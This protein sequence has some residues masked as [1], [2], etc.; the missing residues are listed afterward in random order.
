MSHDIR[1]GCCSFVFG[2]ADLATALDLAR[3]LGF[4]HV[5]V[6]AAD[7]GPRANVDQEQ[8]VADP[9]G[10]AERVRALADARS[11]ELDEVFLCPVF[12]KGKRVEV[13]TGD[14]GLREAVVE[15]FGRIC[16]FAAAA[17][18]R[19]IMAVPGMPREGVSDEAAREHAVRTLRRLVALGGEAGLDI[20]IEPH[21]GSLVEKADRAMRLVE[22]VPGLAFTLDY[23]HF[24]TQGYRQEDIYPLHAHTR[25]MHARQVFGDSEETDH[26]PI[27][28]PAIIRDLVRR[29]WK[30]TIVM[31]YFGH[32][33]R[34]PWRGHAV[35]ENALQARELSE[36]LEAPGE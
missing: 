34:G 8:A 32:I 13:S 17:G 20:N 36:A 12:V 1:I 10:C 22:E 27:D 15:N 24:V 23:A 26:P 33:D 2:K 4:R 18:F 14:D 21:R 30:G 16:Q 35:L 3:H 11:L 9:Q 31:E 29:E 28:F 6:S 5:D 7:I 19:S 25:H